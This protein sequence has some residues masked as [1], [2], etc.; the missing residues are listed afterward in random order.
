VIET[1]ARPEGASLRLLLLR[2]GEP[3]SY[4]RER[5]YGKL[6][7]ALSERGRMQALALAARLRS[8]SIDAVYASP[9]RRA[10]ETASLLSRESGVE[11]RIDP[12]L[13]EID[14]GE[15]EGM[16][17]DESRERF[18]EL[19]HVWMT[20]PTEVIFPQGESFA[21]MDSR[22]N[23]ALAEIRGRHRGGT[24]AVVSHGGV[25][26]IALGEALALPRASLFR[27]GQS[28]AALNVIDYYE[29]SPVVAL[30]N[31]VVPC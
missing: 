3:E 17:Y 30:V 25:N 22:V 9:S 5:C 14:F 7:V 18:P 12:R 4:A 15:L 23:A 11:L 29:G 10:R 26:R 24:V 27:L 1:L 2:H 16:T 21:D 19:Y 20:R 13:S 31:G 6:D 8:A 28:Y